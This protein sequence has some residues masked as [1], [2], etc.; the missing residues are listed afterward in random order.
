MPHY[1]PLSAREIIRA[2]SK[3]GF[4]IQKQRGSHIKLVKVNSKSIIVVNEKEIS[5]VTLS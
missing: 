1:A 4:K 3:S 2:L 5:P